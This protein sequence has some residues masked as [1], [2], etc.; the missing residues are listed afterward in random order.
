ME[1][2]VSRPQKSK[3]TFVKST[4]KL[5]LAEDLILKT[6]DKHHTSEYSQKQL[7]T[8]GKIFCWQKE[9]AKYGSFMMI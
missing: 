1:N 6:L 9:K 7:V 4:I 2:C 3:Q 5:A 8:Y